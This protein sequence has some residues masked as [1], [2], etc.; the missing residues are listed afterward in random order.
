V[1]VD[2]SGPPPLK[3]AA[4]LGLAASVLGLV[5]TV[6]VALG[7]LSGHSPSLANGAWS[8]WI[9]LLAPAALLFGLA[10]MLVVIARD[11]RGWPLMAFA[12]FAWWSLTLV[13]LTSLGPYLIPTAL[14]ALLATAQ[15]WACRTHR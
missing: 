9:A 5:T 7:P 14:L 2:R 12:T 11:D 10:T 8:P 6:V 1:V 13:G 4:R 3:S 15:L